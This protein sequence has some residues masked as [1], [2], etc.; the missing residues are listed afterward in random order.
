MTVAAWVLYF[1]PSGLAGQAT[2]LDLKGTPVDPLK[3][4]VG[5]VVVLIFV[6]T[7]CPVSNRYSPT[8]QRLSAEYRDEAAFWL[9]YPA[10]TESPGMIRKHEQDFGYRFPALR[11]VQH[12]LVKQGRVAITPESAVF[13]ANHRLVYHGRIDNLYENFGRARSTPTTHELDDAIQAA[14][15]GKTLLADTVP[16]VG[17]YIADLP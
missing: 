3:A 15:H 13:D 6:R 1:Y 8:I 10:K 14:I 16:A 5:K 4:S 2:G 7:D 11:D 9:V 12:A 17:C